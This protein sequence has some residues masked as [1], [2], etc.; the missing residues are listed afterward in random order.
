MRESVS[1]AGPVLTFCANRR[2]DTRP[3]ARCEPALASASHEGEFQSIPGGC[4]QDRGHQG[5]CRECCFM[6]ACVTT[7]TIAAKLQRPQ[8]ARLIADREL[9]D[10]PATG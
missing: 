3:F 5:L 1:E 8:Q 7:A 10:G 9:K 6:F 2:K 4:L